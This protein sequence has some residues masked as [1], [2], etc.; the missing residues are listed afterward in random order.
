[1]KNIINVLI[2]LFLASS[3]KAQSQSDTLNYVKQ[4]EINKSQYVNKPFS[5]LLSHMIQMQPKSHWSDNPFRNKKVVES[6]RFKFCGMKYSFKDAVT[7][8]ITWEETFPES[9]VKYLQ[10]KNGYYFTNEEKAFYCNKI[11]KD[12]IVYK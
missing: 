2:F 10:N 4:F 9:D 3:C 11:V 7:I 5:Y 1:M 12:I 6:T 8:N